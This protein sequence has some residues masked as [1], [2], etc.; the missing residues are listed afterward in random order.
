MPVKV[1][2]NPEAFFNALNASAYG[3]VKAICERAV[4]YAKDNMEVL[5]YPSEPGEFP[6]VVTEKLKKGVTY[7]IK[8][9]PGVAVIGK[10]GVFDGDEGY[11]KW[12]E[13]G[14]HKMLPRPWLSL[15]TAQI[16][17][18]YGLRF[19]N[20]SFITTEMRAGRE[21]SGWVDGEMW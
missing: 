15:T 14:T 10:Y 5:G 21:E 4:E 8:V 2:W 13:T 1:N 7:R 11:G 20:A 19:G 18:E 17:A 12:L 9:I 16:E 6:G 3:L